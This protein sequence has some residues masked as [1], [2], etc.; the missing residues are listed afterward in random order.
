[1]IYFFEYLDGTDDRPHYYRR[2]SYGD[3]DIL[4]TLNSAERVWKLENGVVTFVKNRATGTMTTIDEKEF[5][6]VQLKAVDF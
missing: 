3:T 6:M 2:S 5:L 1:M 4:I